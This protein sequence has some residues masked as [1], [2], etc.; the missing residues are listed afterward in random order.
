M[1]PGPSSKHS[2]PSIPA[3]RGTQNACEITL[4]T[5]QAIRAS[6]RHGT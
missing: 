6:A 3:R 5:W 2:R 1:L 4:P